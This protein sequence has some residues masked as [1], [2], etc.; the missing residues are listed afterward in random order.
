MVKWNGHKFKKSHI[1]EFVE[2][3]EEMADG[4]YDRIKQ[5]IKRNYHD[6]ELLYFV[7]YVVCDL[8]RGTKLSDDVYWEIVN[9]F[10]KR[11]ILLQSLNKLKVMYYKDKSQSYLNKLTIERANRMNE[12]KNFYPLLN[13]ILTGDS[14]TIIK[15]IGDASDH[16][17]GKKNNDFIKEMYPILT[18]FQLTQQK[19]Q[20]DLSHRLIENSVKSKKRKYLI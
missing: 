13:S 7:D 11:N 18:D 15:L 6:S 2:L 12:Y 10:L 14:D 16:I 19:K 4:L 17:Y 5:I 1:E 8:F 9:E 20:R 3:L